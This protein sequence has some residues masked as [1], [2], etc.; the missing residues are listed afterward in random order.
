MLG[1]VGR[2]LQRIRKWVDLW[3]WHGS[4]TVAG[5]IS[6]GDGREFVLDRKCEQRPRVTN[7][8]GTIYYFFRLIHQEQM[9]CDGRERDGVCIPEG[10]DYA[11]PRNAGRKVRMLWN[12]HGEVLEVCK[13]RW[14]F[15]LLLSVTASDALISPVFWCPGAPSWSRLDKTGSS[16]GTEFWLTHPCGPEA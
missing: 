15:C 16:L 8:G 2:S 9:I 14:T 1:V 4:R 10:A 7:K 6:G 13:Q 11:G 12:S 5:V 3:W